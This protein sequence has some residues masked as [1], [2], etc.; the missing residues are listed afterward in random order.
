MRKA[1]FIDRDGTILVEPSD[2]QIDSFL[3]FRFVP[4]AISALR[5]LRQHT[6]YEFVMVSNQDGLGTESYPESDFLPTHQLML[7]I[8]HGEGVDF[9]AIHI[10]RSFPADNLPTR[11]PGTGMLTA[12][13]QGDY[14]LARS[15]VRG[16][17][18][19]DLMLARNLG[20]QGVKL[21]ETC[22]W[23]KVCQMVFAGERTATVKR[24]TRETDIE[25]RLNL[26]GNGESDI[27]TGLGFLD[28]MLEQLP[29]HGMMDLYVRCQGDLNVDEH[30]TVED[31]AL[32]LGQCLRQALGDKRGIERYGFCLP[33]DDSLC[34]VALDFGGRPWLVWNAEFHRVCNGAAPTEMFKHFFKSLSDSAMMNINVQARGE[35]EHHLIEGIFKALARS[36]RMAVRRDVNHYQ[37]PSSKGML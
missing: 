17:R 34:Q 10:D 1:L 19:T 29:H 37:L 6:D 20:A 27:H 36:L 32:A 4:G 22:S 30:H 35:N 24:T 2:E 16:D 13:L 11:K 31:T 5:F 3:K 8:L 15:W 18:D 33:M 12:Y 28:H 9:D 7:D 21:G 26:D 25:V 14:D 23:D